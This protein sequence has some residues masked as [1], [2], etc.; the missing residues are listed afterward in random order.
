MVRYLPLLITLDF[1]S[2]LFLQGKPQTLGVKRKAES[3]EERDDVSTLGSMLP[4][5]A[6]PVAE[7]PKAMEEKSSFGG[8]RLTSAVLLEYTEI[9]VL[10]E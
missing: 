10:S 3:E 9:N 8:E 6:S 4:A 1:F 2:V 5:K 7:T